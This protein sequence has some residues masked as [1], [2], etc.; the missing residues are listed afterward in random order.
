MSTIDSKEIVKEII[1]NDGHY[2]G[3][4]QYDSIWQ[5]DNQF[6][7][8]SYKLIYGPNANAML[9][10][11]L[12]SPYCENSR[13]LWSKKTGKTTSGEYFVLGFVFP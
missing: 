11:F 4:P 5:Y 9:S 13:L 7:G 6:G 10:E 1:E 3:D 8:I 2:P 12:S